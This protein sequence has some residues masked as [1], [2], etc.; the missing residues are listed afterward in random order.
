MTI[1]FMKNADISLDE[2]LCTHVVFLMGC[3]PSSQTKRE[4]NILGKKSIN[5]LRRNVN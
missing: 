4:V 1:I 3:T 2:T 5:Y